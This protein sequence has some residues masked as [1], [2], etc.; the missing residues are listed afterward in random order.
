MAIQADIQSP[1]QVE[2][3][4]KSSKVDIDQWTLRGRRERERMERGEGREGRGRVGEG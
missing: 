1:V 3:V 4:F 2:K